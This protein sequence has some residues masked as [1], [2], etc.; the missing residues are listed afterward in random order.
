[1]LANDVSMKIVG[2]F[3]ICLKVCIILGYFP[4]NKKKLKID[5][6]FQKIEIVLEK[7]RRHREGKEGRGLKNLHGAR[8]NKTY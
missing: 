4:E 6:M 8:Q 5:K 3:A 2:T 7:I 1:M